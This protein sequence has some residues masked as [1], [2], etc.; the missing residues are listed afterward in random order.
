MA[1]QATTRR[2]RRLPQIEY[3][4][5]PR[6]FDSADVRR[7][8]WQSKCGRYRVVR[9]HCKLAESRPAK[10]RLPDVYYAMARVVQG[11]DAGGWMIIGRHMSRSA[12]ERTNRE[13]LYAVEI[14]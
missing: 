13:H 9:S 3:P 7:W 14:G 12:A 1:K 5:R 8:I 2:R 4:K 11:G 6:I 10:D